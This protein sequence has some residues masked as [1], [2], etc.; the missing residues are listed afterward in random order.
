MDE[1]KWGKVPGIAADA[2]II[3]LEDSVVPDL[4]ATAR[5][6]AVRY[7]GDEDFFGDRLVLARPNNLETPWGE[8]DI[9]A[10]AA[11]SV[12]LMLYPKTK[13][14]DELEEVRRLLDVHGASPLIFP[15]IET[16]GAV[17]DI[18][19]IAQL[20]GVGGLFT[21]I[22]DLS[23]DAGVPFRDRDGGI[24]PTL[25]HARDQVALAAASV[26]IASTDTVYA[27]NLKDTADVTEAIADSRRRGFTSLV[28]FYPPHVPMIN[29][30]LP[31]S[32]GEL[33]E[34]ADLVARYREAQA[35]GRPAL[36]LEDGRTVLLLDN[37][38]AERLLAEAAVEAPKR[39]DT[40]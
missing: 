27:R 36:V 23:V 20:R 25:N 17:L 2:F 8:D 24:N 21:G 16:A 3:D 31:P 38:R 22:G 33:A 4:K 1:R 10:L 34:A 28:T 37:A 9:A 14:V 30:L 12:R 40:L 32:R 5:E 26:G 6:S 29:R 11:S 39:R 7:L 35:A 15:I 13:S 18:R 19:A